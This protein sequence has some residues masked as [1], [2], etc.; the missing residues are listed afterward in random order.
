VEIVSIVTH[1]IGCSATIRNIEAPLSLGRSL[2][3]DP[4]TGSGTRTMF[5]GTKFKPADPV[6]FLEVVRP[7]GD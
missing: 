6:G 4:G 3:R 5:R 7:A 1:L 2:H